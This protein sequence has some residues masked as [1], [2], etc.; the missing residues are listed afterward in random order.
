MRKEIIFTGFGG[1]GI[2]LMGVIIARMMEHFPDLQV[3][4]AQSY[5]PASRGGACRTDVVIS[6]QKINYP[7]SSRPDVMIFMSEEARKRL[8]SEADPERTLVVYDNTLIKSIPAPYDKRTF[9]VPATGEAEK[10]FK[11][12]MVANIYMLGAVIEL[13]NPGSFEVLKQIVSKSVPKKYEEL[14]IKALEA[15]HEYYRNHKPA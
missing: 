9:A 12:R 3:T 7:K 11:N 4:Q 10:E 13:I 5:G 6:D 2:I 1:Q 15:G 14:N 8:L